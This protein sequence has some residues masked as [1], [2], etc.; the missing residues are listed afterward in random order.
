MAKKLTPIL[1]AALL[2]FLSP[3]APAQ[4]ACTVCSWEVPSAPNTSA[5]PCEDLAA[6]A[7]SSTRSPISRIDVRADEIRVQALTDGV[8]A[9]GY[10]SFG[11]ALVGQLNQVGV[12]L[13]EGQNP[14]ALQGAALAGWVTGVE[15][16][17]VK[18]CADNL[19]TSTSRAEFRMEEHIESFVKAYAAHLPSFV[20]GMGTFCQSMSCPMTPIELRRAAVDI[21]R[22]Q[23]TPEYL[24]KARELTGQFR[25]ILQR[26]YESAPGSICNDLNQQLTAATASIIR[27]FTDTVSASRH[28]IESILGEYYT[29]ERRARAQ[30]IFEAARSDVKDFVAV[31][32]ADAPTRAQVLEQYDNMRIH[33]REAPSESEYT[34][35]QGLQVY[36]PGAFN[37]DDVY[38]FGLTFFTSKNATYS[39]GMTIGVSEHTESI[40]IH[41]V[42]LLEMDENPFLLLQVMAHELGHKL[43]PQVS[44]LNGH[45]L[46]PKWEELLQCFRGAGSIRM[47]E[48]QKEEVIS[49]YIA[50]EVMAR[51][52]AQ[53]PK[54]QRLGALAAASQYSCQAE[55]GLPRLNHVGS[56]PDDYLRLSGIYGANP[57]LRR[58][59][60]CEKD[61]TKFKSCGLEDSLL[62]AAISSQQGE[63]GAPS[64][65]DRSG[66]V[67]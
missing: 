62:D 57:S 29:S 24:G 32:G 4:Q 63:A 31:L 14:A 51:H 38:G 37:P 2:C 1:L 17:D 39:P 64:S 53:L 56:H 27:G 52:L 42:M 65:F 48:S 19:R 12:E 59:L 36:D 6:Y 22:L 49:D 50:A 58:V 7:C 46:S 9:L 61:S 26:Y 43:G 41:P 23:G 21:Y 55:G 66:G 45:D 34:P 16:K 11:E 60:S 44:R 18:D 15:F 33:W 20:E 67:Q 10:S 3:L 35:H 13:R 28:T 5:D 47:M 30:A 25:D 8:A 54:E 40:D